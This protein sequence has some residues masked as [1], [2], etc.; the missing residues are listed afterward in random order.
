MSCRAS[1]VVLALIWMA[2]IASTASAT[3]AP[4]TADDKPWQILTAVNAGF[5]VANGINLAIHDPN[6]VTGILGCAVA[7]TSFLAVA[8]ELEFSGTNQGAAIGLSI[9]TGVSFLVG[10]ANIYRARSS[11]TQA[12]AVSARLSSPR[13]V[14]TRRAMGV[15]FEF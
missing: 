10:F 1:R 3:V 4:E 14:F 7:M 11:A 15:V 6:L 8:G 2:M 9:A 12:G 13:I 5:A